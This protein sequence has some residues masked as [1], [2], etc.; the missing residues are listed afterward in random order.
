MKWVIRIQLLGLRNGLWMQTT[1]SYCMVE[2]G[3][4]VKV[5]PA[6]T[7]LEEVKKFNPGGYFISNG[8]G[9]PA[10]MDYAIETCKRNNERR[11]NRY[12]EFVSVT[13]CW[14]WPMIFLLLKCIMVIAD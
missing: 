13:S 11:I 7:N 5:F 1:Y 9:D 3:A 14:H 10:A 8:P 4:Y 12:L 2:R 6:K